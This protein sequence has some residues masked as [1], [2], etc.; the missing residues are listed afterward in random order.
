MIMVF[1]V[2]VVV[3]VVA[4]LSFCFCFCFFLFCFFSNKALFGTHTQTLL[5]QF[6]RKSKGP[7]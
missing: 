3:A 5:R 1:F 2:V 4:V 7:R 6:D